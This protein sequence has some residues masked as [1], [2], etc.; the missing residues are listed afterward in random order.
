MRPTT[1]PT[2]FSAP[3]HVGARRRQAQAGTSKSLAGDVVAGQYEKPFVST[4]V[5]DDVGCMA[6]DNGAELLVDR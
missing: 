4:G 1:S 3:M 6:T 2:V 5:G